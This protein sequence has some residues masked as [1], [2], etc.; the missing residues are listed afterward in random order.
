MRFLDR[1]E[2]PEEK[3]RLQR[4]GGVG[5]GLLEARWT[6]SDI[7]RLVMFVVV[8]ICGIGLFDGSRRVRQWSLVHAYVID[9][10][11]L[12]TPDSEG[13]SLIPILDRATSPSVDCKY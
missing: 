11:S 5:R 8:G 12:C 13:L 6:R 9:P 2:R 10:F 1:E 3:A 4:Q 7:L